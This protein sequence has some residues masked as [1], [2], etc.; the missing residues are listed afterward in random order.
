MTDYK[1]GDRVR[2]EFEGTIVDSGDG[3]LEFDNGECLTTEGLTIT[4]I[5]PTLPTEF[6]SVVELE[7]GFRLVFDGGAWS[8][9]NRDPET[10]IFAGH[11]PEEVA[12]LN[13]TVIREGI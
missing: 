1:P 3:W 10:F 6:G 5:K 9:I 8:G 7:D 4:R 13:F 11:Q 2:V 12:K